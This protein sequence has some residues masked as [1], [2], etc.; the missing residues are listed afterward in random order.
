MWIVLHHVEFLGKRG[1]ARKAGEVPRLEANASSR[2]KAP[3]SSKL[4]EEEGLLGTGG[5]VEGSTFTA[6]RM[7]TPPPLVGGG[8]LRHGPITFCVWAKFR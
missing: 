7:I 8:Y 4:E 1:G 6:E 2:L 5:M 3:P